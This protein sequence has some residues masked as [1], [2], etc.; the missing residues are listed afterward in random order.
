MKSR[1]GEK[2]L[3]VQKPRLKYPGYIS[4]SVLII[5]I[6]QVTKKAA[7]NSLWG[8]PPIEVLPVLQWTLVTNRGAA[9]GFLSDAGGLQHYFFTTLAAL[10]SAFILVWLWRCHTAN[11]L[12][13]WGLAM[14]L[15]GATGNLI[16]RL[17]Y[18]YV[19]DFISLHYQNLY[20]PAFNIAD[21][22]ITI[23]A[24]LLIIDNFCRAGKRL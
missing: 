1:P 22:S 6:D 21:F 13:A 10:V 20:F 11:R 16:D 8:Q 7:Y 4:I 18:R 9:F 24:I 14:I 19:I 12:L 5:I 3:K 17:Q 2:E 15:A 23:G